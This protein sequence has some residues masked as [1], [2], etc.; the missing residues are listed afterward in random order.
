MAIFDFIMPRATPNINLISTFNKR[1]A[2][3]TR[4]LSGRVCHAECLKVSRN[5]AKKETTT[6]EF[7][8]R[9]WRTR[10]LLQFAPRQHNAKALRQWVIAAMNLGRDS[11]H[12]KLR[13]SSSSPPNLDV[14]V[15]LFSLCSNLR[16]TTAVSFHS[17]NSL[18]AR[19][20]FR[21][22]H[23]S[24]EALT[25]ETFFAQETLIIR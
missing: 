6:V 5:M 22:Y 2:K 4:R 7:K 8:I 15:I 10:K 1:D 12:P 19:N 13:P 25:V 20:S 14:L 18:A 11:L 21:N 16:S 3:R 23:R 17:A 24:R 9:R